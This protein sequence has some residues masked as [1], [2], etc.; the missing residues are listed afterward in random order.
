MRRAADGV[1][2]LLGAS[3]GPALAA[4]VA[5]GIGLVAGLSLAGSV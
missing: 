5:A 2:T 1:L 4:V 3:M